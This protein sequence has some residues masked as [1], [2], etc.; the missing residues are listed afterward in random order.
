M[1]LF[2]RVKWLGRQVNHSPTSTVEGNN[3]RS[4]TSIPPVCLHGGNGEYLNFLLCSKSMP[5]TAAAVELDDVNFSVREIPQKLGKRTQRPVLI[6]ISKETVHGVEDSVR[7]R[8]WDT[9]FSV[10]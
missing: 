1:K 5:T 2:P 8:T 4:Y 3:D 9:D 7:F 6:Y 10:C